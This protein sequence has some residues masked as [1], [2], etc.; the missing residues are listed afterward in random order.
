MLNRVALLFLPTRRYATFDY[1]EGSYRP[2]DMQRLDILAHGR[3]VDALC[4]MVH[5]ST[6]QATGR[7]LLAKL[8]AMLDRQQ[9]EVVLQVGARRSTAGA[10]GTPRHSRPSL[11]GV[12]GKGWRLSQGALA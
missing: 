1:E 6:A 4:R 2:A 9:F 8:A 7:A 11:C 10:H 12:C 5:R 3:P